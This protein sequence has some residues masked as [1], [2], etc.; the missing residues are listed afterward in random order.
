[1]SDD[2]EKNYNAEKRARDFA[3]AVSLIEKIEFSVGGYISGGVRFEIELKAEDMAVTR[4][5][6]L[7]LERAEGRVPYPTDREGFLDE[8]R[9]LDLGAWKPFYRPEEAV[10]D[11]SEWSLEISYKDGREPFE[12]W[13]MNAYPENF[14]AFLK[15]LDAE[16]LLAYLS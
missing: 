7:S 11:G 8:I 4:A 14:E 10:L 3:E 6:L 13:G 1:M 9:A 2:Y 12:S 16:N 5:A 15:L